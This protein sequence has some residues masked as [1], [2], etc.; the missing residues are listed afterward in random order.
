MV[1]KRLHH[2]SKDNSDD[3]AIAEYTQ[4]V[5]QV[6]HDKEEKAGYIEMFR[7]P[8]W[9]RRVFVAI[10]LQFAA[11]ST[12]VSTFLAGEGQLADMNRSWVSPITL[13]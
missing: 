2:N 7:R 8:T 1:L 13:S 12:G 3:L 9:R 5:R 6:S 4:I 10:F 11:Q